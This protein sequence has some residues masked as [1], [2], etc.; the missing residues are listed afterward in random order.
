MKTT[1]EKRKMK[2]YGVELEKFDYV[3]AKNTIKKVDFIIADSENEALEKVY[4]IHGDMI[5]IISIREFV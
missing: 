2:E 4:Y 3:F 1:K 5:D